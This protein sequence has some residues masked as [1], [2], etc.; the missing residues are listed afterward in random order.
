MYINEYELTKGLYLLK[1]PAEKY[2]GLVDH[3]A[4]MDVGNTSSLF[5]NVGQRPIVIEKVEGKGII[6]SYNSKNWTILGKVKDHH[7]LSA[8]LRLIQAL[9][10]P[11]YDLFGNNCEH[12]ARFIAEG[13]KES[14]QVNSFGAL[15]LFFGVVMLL[16]QD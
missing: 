15:A 9:E 5:P 2:W 3:Y 7:I 1:R 12:F 10:N 4:V 16:S 6:A 13:K 8:T 14:E 11:T